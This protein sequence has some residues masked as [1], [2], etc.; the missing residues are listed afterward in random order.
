[1]DSCLGFY[2]VMDLC[3]SCSCSCSY[4]CFCS[5][6]CCCGCGCCCWRVR[7][8]DMWYIRM[9]SRCSVSLSLCRCPKVCCSTTDCIFRLHLKLS[10][11]ICSWFVD[12]FAFISFILLLNSFWM[13]LWNLDVALYAYL[14][15]YAKHLFPNNRCKIATWD[16]HL[17]P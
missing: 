10:W 15:G 8:S 6:C 16:K 17:D 3:C 5:C 7:L 2:T 14:L 1:M 9:K 12:F 4:S 13:Y 11:A